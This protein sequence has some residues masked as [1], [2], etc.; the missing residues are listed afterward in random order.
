MMKKVIKIK[1]FVVMLIILINTVAY[2]GTDEYC[3]YFYDSVSA[4]SLPDTCLNYPPVNYKSFDQTNIIKGAATS[5]SFTFNAVNWKLFTH[6]VDDFST[7]TYIGEAIAY[8]FAMA[9]DETGDV[10]YGLENSSKNLVTIDQTNGAV[11]VV[12]PLTNFIDSNNQTVSGLDIAPD[13]TCYV[14]STD[15]STSILYTCD[16]TTGT[17][18]LVGTLSSTPALI[19]IAADCD[20]NLYGHDIVHDSI[21]SINVVT[22]SATLIG[23][24]GYDTNLAQDLTYDRQEKK[25]YG[26]ILTLNQNTIYGPINT[27][28]GAVTPLAVD[29]PWGQFV[30]AS[31]TSCLL[32]DFI[33]R[34][35]FDNSDLIFSNGFE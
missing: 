4:N 34:D 26:Y 5:T 15:T 30:G 28:T 33:F 35:G 9:F 2:A 13:G 14:S 27:S 16:L 3:Q 32:S 8:I 31:K 10:L 24:T 1:H 21:F 25:L 6:V 17:L 18:T 23:L 22:G 19:G 29:D 12:G 7:Q 11:T 20:G